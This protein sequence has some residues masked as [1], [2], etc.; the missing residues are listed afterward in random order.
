MTSQTAPPAPARAGASR[1]PFT[2]RI[3]AWSAA[4]PWKAIIGWTLF[5]AVCFGA[6]TAAG[7]EQVAFS[8]FWIGEAGEA[9]AM[10]VDNGIAA[11]AVE[12]VLI[13]SPTGALDPAAAEAAAADLTERMSALPEVAAVSA[14]V[15]A[16]HG[17]AV[18]VSMTMS[19][20]SH[21]AVDHVEPLLRTTAAVQEAHPGLHIAETGGKSMSVELNDQL[22]AELAGVERFT[23][24]ITLAIL[25][26]VFGS[27]LLAGVPLLLAISSIVAALGVYALSSHFFPDAG[28]AVAS[29]LAMIGMAVGVDYSLFYLKRVREERLRSGG[30]DR[31][32][33]AVE[34][35]AA[36]AG[37]TIVTSGIA[38]IV[39]L[40]GL[41]LVG[42]VIFSSIATACIIVV[43]IAMASSL[44]VLPALLVKT[45]RRID[46]GKL[47]RRRANP[48]QSR[49]WTVLLRPSLRRPAVTAVVGLVVMGGLAVPALAMTTSVEGK[50]TFPKSLQTIGAYD[51]LVAAFPEA[52]VSHSV[53]ATVD[54][55]DAEALAAAVARLE[56][57]AQ[58]SA[59]F[60]AT[61]Q[62]RIRV[63]QDGSAIALDLPVPYPTSDPRAERSLDL[64][65]DDLVPATIGEIEGA[66][67]AVSGEPAYAADYSAHQSSRL[68]LVVGFVLLATLVIMLIAFRSLVFAALSMVL[69]L[70]STLAAWGAMVLVFQGTWAEGLLDFDSP[71]FI[72]SRTP[73]LV[74]AILFGLS[75]DYQLFVMSR[76]REAAKR[77][78]APREA[79]QQGILSSASVVTSAAVIMM[80]VFVAFVFIDRI[81]MKQLGFALALG[82]LLDAV[83]VRVMMLPALMSMVDRL[84]RW[85]AD[86][87]PSTRT[88]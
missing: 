65:R 62:P 37:R 28:G 42:D 45:G 78:L 67:Y 11:P 76:I 55:A 43:A 36:T 14:P 60:V 88:R 19:M 23:L 39:S 66:D 80:S 57:A 20:P 75:L 2:V 48:G 12:H 10:A 49:L 53:I 54:A 63:S 82:V 34:L 24:P 9:E 79:V 85:P 30:D 31:L 1:R 18:M 72:G 74:F 21:E 64:L 26:V 3:A 40:A 50:E 7:T 71:G 5:V 47:L 58:E 6:G 29:V 41:Y 27:L 70:L 38:V 22:G 25:F 8:D 4:H 73:L 44:T 16:D 13:T 69:N 17:D 77:G 46:G 68:F 52:G 81:E 33:A 59:L 15:T 35:A 56:A 84:G 51:D 32:A 87:R 86:W 61:D 83:I